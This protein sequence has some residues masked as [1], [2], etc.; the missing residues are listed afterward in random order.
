MANFYHETLQRVSGLYSYK[1]VHWKTPNRDLKITWAALTF[2][3]RHLTTFWN[4][5]LAKTVVT[6]TSGIN[7]VQAGKVHCH[8]NWRRRPP[9]ALQTAQVLLREGDCDVCALQE[10]ALLLHRVPVCPFRRSGACQDVCQG[11]CLTNRYYACF[12]PIEGYRTSRCVSNRSW[13][14]ALP[15]D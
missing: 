5:K 11:V 4:R 3:Q 12:K 14:C 9:A 8:D 7:C 2:R 6:L 13:L 10:A 15:I 1:H